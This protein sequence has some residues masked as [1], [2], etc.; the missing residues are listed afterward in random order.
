MKLVRL[1]LPG[2]FA[3]A[4]C[5]GAE[6]PLVGDAHVSATNPAINFGSLTTLNVGNSQRAFLQFNPSA[7]LPAGVTASQIAKASLVLFVNRVTTAGAI[8]VNLAGGPWSELAITN[9]NAP[10]ISTTVATAVAVSTPGTFLAIDATAVVKEWIGGQPNN[11]FV[12]TPSHLSPSTSIVLDSKETTTTSHPAMLLIELAGE[13]G[14]AGPTG[15][16]GPQ[17]S[18]GPQGPQGPQG[19]LGLTGAQGPQGPQGPPGP[20]STGVHFASLLLINLDSSTLVRNFEVEGPST[21]FLSDFDLHGTIIAFGGACELTMTAT[22][23]PA[24]TGAQIINM[25]VLRVTAGSPLG[26]NATENLTGA[27]Q[28]SAANSTA[29]S[30]NTWTISP[31]D[32]VAFRTSRAVADPPY[33]NPQHVY[34]QWACN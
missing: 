2:T 29:T 7:T 4:L 18:T 8:D 28:L 1:L 5:W 23:V 17:G 3:V 22:A 21:G 26:S 9:G 25:R 30:L 27:L 33:N 12:V 14:P 10:A 31:G 24:L 34:V 20:A 15:P 13:P 11:G 6:A 16:Q 19:P 32:R